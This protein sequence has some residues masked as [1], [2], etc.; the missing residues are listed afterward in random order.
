MKTIQEEFFLTS[1]NGTIRIF[2]HMQKIKNKIK[3]EDD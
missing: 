3:D 1:S 2:G